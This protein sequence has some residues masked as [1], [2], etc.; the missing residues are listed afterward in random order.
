MKE[1]TKRIHEVV[2]H[3]KF[4]K[5]NSFD[6]LAEYLKKEQTKNIPYRFTI[7]SEY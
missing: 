7:L 4:I 1:V 5:R 3:A 2:G 6:E